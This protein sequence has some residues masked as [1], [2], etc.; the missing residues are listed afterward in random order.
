V[1]VQQPVVEGELAAGT[2][3]EAER[4]ADTPVGAELVAGMPVAL[5]VAVDQ[6]SAHFAGHP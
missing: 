2:P 1:L 3:G 4:P 5:A 6:Q